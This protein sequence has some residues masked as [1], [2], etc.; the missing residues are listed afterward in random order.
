[1]FCFQN[2]NLIADIWNKSN[3]WRFIGLFWYTEFRFGLDNSLRSPQI[4]N[5]PWTHQNKLLRFHLAALHGSRRRSC[6]ATFTSCWGSQIRGSIASERRARLRT[7]LPT[8]LPILFS[9][10]QRPE[11]TGGPDQRLR[12]RDNQIKSQEYSDTATQP[13]LT[14]CPNFLP[15]LTQRTR[16]INADQ[17][18][19][20][21]AVGCRST[22]LH[23]IW[24]HLGS[25]KILH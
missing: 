9:S 6:V 11:R 10:N 24:V 19:V 13:A 8:S 20:A 14:A 7:G 2:I 4:F 5:S 18:T 25:K 23:N 17:S 21:T 15:W 16:G 12:T 22:L 1:M 3:I